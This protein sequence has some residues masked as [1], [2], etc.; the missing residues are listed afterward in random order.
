MP[1]LIVAGWDVSALLFEDCGDP[2]EADAG[3]VEF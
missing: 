2:A 1:S 3:V